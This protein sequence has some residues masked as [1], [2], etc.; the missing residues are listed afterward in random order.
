[1]DNKG[2]LSQIKKEKEDLKILREKVLHDCPPEEAFWTCHGTIIRNIYELANTVRALNEFAFK[3]HVNTDHNKNDFAKW[4][5]EVL[6]DQTLA[7]RLQD[8]VEQQT[9]VNIILRRIKELERA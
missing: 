1:M 3:Y 6:K 8:V 5:A 4:I 9:Y 7:G 2:F